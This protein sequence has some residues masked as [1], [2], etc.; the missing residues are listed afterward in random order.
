M[1]KK[2][3]LFF[4]LLL[5]ACLFL[6]L[7][8]CT[9]KPNPQATDQTV[10]TYDRYAI[11]QGED[12]S[13]SQEYGAVF[14]LALPFVLSLAALFRSRVRWFYTLVEIVAALAVLGLVG[15]HA[16]T[17]TQLASGGYLALLSGISL[18]FINIYLFFSAF[19]KSNE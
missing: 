17:G 16:F 2:I 4:S 13:F 6:P 15:I 11:M 5:L 10:K 14:V 9:I 7:S 3:K 12:I 8:T 19:K 18:F 1:L